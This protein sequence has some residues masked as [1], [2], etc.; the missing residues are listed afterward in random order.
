M[1]IGS[2]TTFKPAESSM[3]HIAVLVSPAPCKAAR[4]AK[5]RKVNGRVRKMISM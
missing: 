4:N 1:K 2:I 5:N 3:S